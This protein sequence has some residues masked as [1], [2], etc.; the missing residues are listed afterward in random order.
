MK[1]D[2]I[3]ILKKKKFNHKIILN[4]NNRKMFLKKYL[5]LA[6]RLKMNYE[7]KYI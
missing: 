6:K 7:K 1:E 4:Q 5:K 3:N 2:F